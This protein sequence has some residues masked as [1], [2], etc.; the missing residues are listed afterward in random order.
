MNKLSRKIAVFLVSSQL[1]PFNGGQGSPSGAF[2]A[3]EDPDFPRGTIYT[4]KRMKP[5]GYRAV[6]SYGNG[7]LAAGS[8]GRIDRISTSG[9]ITKT[10]TFPGEAFNSLYSDE[11]T[12]IAAGDKG[13]LLISS[14]SGEFRKV[15]S[16]TGSD[17]NSLTVFSGIIIAGAD[18]GEIIEGD[19]QG[20]FKKIKPGLKGNIVSLSAGRSGCY[21]VT[22][23]GEIVHSPDG[24]NWKITDFNQLYAGYY[25]PCRFTRVLATENRIAIAGYGDDGSPVMFF[26]SQG[27]VWTERLLNYTDEL[28]ITGFLEAIPNDLLYDESSDQFFVAC[29]KGKLMKLPSCSHC[30]KLTVFCGENLEGISSRDNILIT[31]GEDFI[32]R[33]LDIR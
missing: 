5:E 16:G 14:D 17:I 1:L 25:K 20:S 27:N 19:F 32:I 13:T 11:Q 7:F 31:V 2:N 22:D 6:I 21:G 30:N 33:T 10:E 23:A 15:L 8:G 28:G 12:V 29:S 24:L 18:H 9:E 3:P 4:A 26:S